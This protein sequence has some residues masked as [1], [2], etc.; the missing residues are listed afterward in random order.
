MAFLPITASVEDGGAIGIPLLHAQ[1]E[2][3]RSNFTPP[4]FT[5]TE[6]QIVELA[7]RDGLAS[8]RAPNRW[9]RLNSWIFGERVSPRLANGRLESLRR[10]AVEAWHRSYAVRPSFL[11]AFLKAGFSESQLETL[12]A[13][14]SAQRRVQGS[15]R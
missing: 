3:P 4:D 15:R 14:I 9:D 12:L 5:P 6:W 13:N 8:L 7:R 11:E 1:S 2:H 10:L